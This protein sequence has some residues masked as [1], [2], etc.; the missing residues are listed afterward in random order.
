MN[1]KQLLDR[2][3]RSLH[4][5][6]AA[7][8]HWVQQNAPT[9]EQLF[10][11]MAQQQYDWLRELYEDELPLAKL[12]DEADLTLELEGP[13]TRV[14]HPRVSVVT[15]T[16][17]C[18][19][20]RVASVAK[21]ISGPRTA[22]KKRFKLPA[23]MELGFIS[24]ARGPGL[25]FGFTIPDPPAATESILGADDPTYQAV[26]RAVFAIRD[27]S[28]SVAEVEG[29]A[30]VAEH[31]R[32]TFED[33]RLRD[34]ALVAVKDLA[35][36]RQAG[37]TT[38]RV[39]G[40]GVVRHEPRPM[41]LD[42][43]RALAH[44]VVSPVR[45]RENYAVKGTVREIDLD[46]RRFDLRNIMDGEQNDLRCVY[47]KNATEEQ[48]KLWLGQS[49]RVEGKVERDHNGRPRLLQIKKMEV[50]GVSGWQQTVFEFPEESGE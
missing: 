5:Q 21:T 6:I 8:F 7:T 3:A 49:L 50:V 14:A 38:V 47:G 32:Q 16:F 34:A 28:I 37:L 11:S 17:K 44:L 33:P 35:P 25:R 41:T 48:A 2:K 24:V 18:V 31:V 22:T 1:W 26:R 29:E 13:A 20:E 15:R 27:L 23:E 42:T 46:S 45:S 30:E 40:R 36:T 10:E 19:Q 12:L 4:E 39:N 9:D 43:R